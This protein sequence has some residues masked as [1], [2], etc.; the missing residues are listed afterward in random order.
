VHPER[1]HGP[2]THALACE[3]GISVAWNLELGSVTLKRIGFFCFPFFEGSAVMVL[4]FRDG[5]S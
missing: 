5:P 1:R 3:Q 2:G 4:G